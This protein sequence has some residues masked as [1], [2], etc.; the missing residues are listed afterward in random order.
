MHKC[1]RT[2]ERV[3]DEASNTG[4][5][6]EAVAAYS[7]VLLLCPTIPNAIMIKCANTMLKHG[8]PHETSSAATRVCPP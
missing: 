1:V 3:G 6:D 4:E 5:R 8:S 2:L 7:T